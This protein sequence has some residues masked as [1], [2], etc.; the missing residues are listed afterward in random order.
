[1]L[2]LPSVSITDTHIINSKNLKS[3]VSPNVLYR[4][5]ID[6]IKLT[7]S[8]IVYVY[9][10]SSVN[11][12]LTDENSLETTGNWRFYIL[13]PTVEK[14]KWSYFSIIHPVWISKTGR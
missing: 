6:K 13:G 11:F 9:L 8:L 4:L 12:I 2:V 7:F 5:I 1:M 10:H 14:S 3:S